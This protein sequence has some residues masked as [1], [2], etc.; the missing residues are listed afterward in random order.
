MDPNDI[1]LVQEVSLKVGYAPGHKDIST[2]EFIRSFKWVGMDTMNMFRV[3][4]NSKYGVFYS[5][6]FV[7]DSNFF[8]KVIRKVY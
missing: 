8:G 4:G 7:S 5:N 6:F 1:H 2:K 3:L